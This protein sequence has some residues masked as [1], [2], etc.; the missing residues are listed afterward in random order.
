MGGFES[1]KLSELFTGKTLIALADGM[2]T[3]PLYLAGKLKAQLGVAQENLELAISTYNQTVLLAVQQVSDALTDLALADERAK[4]IDK[5]IKEAK[6]LYDLTEQK[7]EH[8]VSDKLS[9]LNAF[10]NLYVQKDLEVRVQLARYEAAVDLIRAIG[11]G[12][13]EQCR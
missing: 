8:A 1:I 10:E 11:G 13:H 3:L 7:Y 5:A 2:A 4:T 6:A 12:Y 9:V